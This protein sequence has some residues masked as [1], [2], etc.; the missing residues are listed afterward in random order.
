MRPK[1]Q[2]SSVAPVTTALRQKIV[3]AA[4]AFSAEQLPRKLLC[5]GHDLRDRANANV[6]SVKLDDDI[7]A[8][9]QPDRLPKF[10]GKADT[11]RTRNVTSKSF[12]ALFGQFDHFAI[13]CHPQSDCQHWQSSATVRNVLKTAPVLDP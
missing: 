3:N 5:A 8:A 9:F 7:T 10:S 13:R 2:A 1:R 4:I 6:L 11:A 12:F